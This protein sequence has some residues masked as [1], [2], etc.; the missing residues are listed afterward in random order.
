MDFMF[1][2]LYVTDYIPDLPMQIYDVKAGKYA[3]IGQNAVEDVFETEY[4]SLGMYYSTDCRE[5]EAFSSP[6]K[7]SF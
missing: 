5:E 1:D 3:R 6:A 4:F 2:S 7:F